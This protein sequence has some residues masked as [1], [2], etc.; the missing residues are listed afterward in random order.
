M[1]EGL[2][3]RNGWEIMSTAGVSIAP[4]MAQRE[5][6]EREREGKEKRMGYR[7]QK[8][9]PSCRISGMDS[10]QFARP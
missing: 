8:R 2:G 4:V 3:E 7:P 6:G 10:C 9:E 5:E 1:K